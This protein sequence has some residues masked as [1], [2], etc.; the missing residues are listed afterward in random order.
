MR[1]NQNEENLCWESYDPGW[2]F[3]DRD[4]HDQEFDIPPGY[5]LA[6]DQS[7]LWFSVARD[8]PAVLTPQAQ[9]HRFVEG[10]WLGDVAELFIK[11]ASQDRYLE[12]NLAAN[13]AWWSAGF[14]SPRER[15]STENTPIPGVKTY[16]RTSP[17][18]CWHAAA[19]IPLPF[20]E[21]EFGFG[22]ATQLNVTFIL[23]S[24]EQKFISISKLPGVNPDFHQP[25][26]F[27]GI[28]FIRR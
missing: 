6:T 22:P 21:S 13:G 24:P 16:S 26:H 14:L 18:G 9:P 3:A 25:N 20:L 19:T 2:S 1:V 11:H 12:L 27:E 15:S 17:D 5:A 10:L 28:E 8:R 4:W 7:N 23:D